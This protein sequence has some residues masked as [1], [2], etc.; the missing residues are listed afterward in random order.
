MIELVS[1]SPPPARVPRAPPPAARPPRP[2][3]LRSFRAL[4]DHRPRPPSGRPGAGSVRYDRAVRDYGILVRGV[5]PRRRLATAYRHHHRRKRHAPRRPYE[6]GV[7]LLRRTRPGASD[8][9]R[10]RAAVVRHALRNGPS[11]RGLDLPRA[12]GHGRGPR[13]AHRDS[14]QEE[15][16]AAP[17]AVAAD[18][19]RC[20]RERRRD[21][22]RHAGHPRYAGPP[23]GPRVRAG[24]RLCRSERRAAAAPVA[25]RAGHRRPRL[26]QPGRGP[27]R[28]LLQ[29]LH[30]RDGKPRHP[31]GPPGACGPRRR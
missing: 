23:S 28:R 24:P 25:G 11:G 9:H 4:P 27:V 30:D 20:L 18:R 26:R 19:R 6:R 12:G 22:S 14:S 29:S 21:A 8:P 2:T 15:F 17:R 7:G 10:R 5:R 16:P 1:F 3:R 31:G 13:A